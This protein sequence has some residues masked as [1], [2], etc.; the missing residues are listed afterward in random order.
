MFKKLKIRFR[1]SDPLILLIFLLSCPVEAQILAP[2]IVG[3]QFLLGNYDYRQNTS[4]TLVSSAHTS[5][6]IYLKKEVYH[7][8]IK[9]HEAAAQKGVKLRIISGT[10]NFE[11]QKK[12][13]EKKWSNLRELT[14]EARANLILEY[15]SMPATSR[16][17]WGTEID[18]NALENDYFESGEGKIIYEWLLENA[19]MYGFYQVYSSQNTGRTGYK[20]EKWHWSYLPLA[21]PYL[22]SYNEQIAYKDITGFEGSHLAEVKQ[23]IKYYVNGISKLYT[24]IIPKQL[25]LSSPPLPSGPLT[26]DP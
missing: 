6:K 16:H 20:E 14:P 24:G 23:M 17:H 26:P 7:A 15:S 4:F 25:S 9:M 8:F 22:A 1:K 3:K 2:E 21:G 10:R 19:H 13:W 18:L 5:R 11:E 12:I